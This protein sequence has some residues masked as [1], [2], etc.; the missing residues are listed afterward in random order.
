MHMSRQDDVPR[1]GYSDMHEYVTG[2]VIYTHFQH[3]SSRGII[4]THRGTESFFTTE[5]LFIVIVDLPN[6]ENRHSIIRCECDRERGPSHINTRGVT[7]VKDSAASAIVLSRLRW[8]QM[9]GM[10]CGQCTERFFSSVRY[11]VCSISSDI[12]DD[13]RVLVHF[14]SVHT[15]FLVKCDVRW[16]SVSATVPVPC[17]WPSPH[18]DHLLFSTSRLRD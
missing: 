12:F 3:G 4:G 5:I 18:S 9:R 2:E 8:R 13:C 11:A 6:V 1:V 17:R 10:S 7:G 15:R 16:S 14:K